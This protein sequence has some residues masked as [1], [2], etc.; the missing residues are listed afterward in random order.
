MLRF[1]VSEDAINWHALNG[2]KPVVSADTTSNTGGI[3]DPH[4]LRGAKNDGYYIVATDMYTIK[5]GWGFNPGIVLMHSKNLTDWSSTAIDFTKTYPEKFGN[6][7]WVWAPQTVYDTNV[8]K[9]L[10]YFTVKFKGVKDPD[11]SDPKRSTLD[12]YCAY[13]NADFTGLEGEPQLMYSATYGAIDG[14]IIIDKEGMYH[15]FY[16][17]NVKDEK[18]KE[19]KNG[20]KQA[21]SSSL[22]GPWYEEEGFIDAYADSK[23]SVEGSGVFRLNPKDGDGWVLMY[24]LYSNGRYEFQR[25]SDLYHFT[26]RPESFTK[27]FYPR[28]GTVLPITKK[29]LKTLQKKW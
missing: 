7:Q 20:I 6:V 27:D 2:N 18:G 28:H 23:I 25:S 3:R 15:F 1:A 16:K 21:V 5:N 11:A 19:Y 12:Y 9:Y 10:I 22:Y 29:E 8:G 17:G 13:A 4:I 26:P 14:D 24:D